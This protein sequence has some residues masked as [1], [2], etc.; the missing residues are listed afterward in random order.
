MLRRVVAAVAAAA[1]FNMLVPIGASA[2]EDHSRA[3][4]TVT[5]PNHAGMD[6][7]V[8]GSH[9]AKESS[10]DS[11]ARDGARRHS[12]PSLGDVTGCH[13]N[14]GFCSGECALMSGCAPHVF[15]ASGVASVPPDHGARISILAAGA[16]QGPDTAPDHPPPRA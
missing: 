2:C 12:G 9:A 3:S 7:S 15:P 11:S 14:G 5:K 6:H 1:L 10:Q 13:R 4:G 16:W 8:H